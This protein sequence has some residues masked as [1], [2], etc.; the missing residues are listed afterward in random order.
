MYPNQVNPTDQPVNI[1]APQESSNRRGAPNTLLLVIIAL[2]IALLA[3]TVGFVSGTTS[4]KDTY[5][6]KL[7]QAAKDYASLKKELDVQSIGSGSDV[8][9]FSY[10]NIPEW[11]IRMPLN[12]KYTDVVY[13]LK[14]ELGSTYVEITSATL[15]KISTC[16]NYEGQIGTITKAKSGTVPEPARQVT[17]FDEQIYMFKQFD[18]TCT[19]NPQGVEAPYKASILEQFA[20]LEPMPVER[21]TA[22]KKD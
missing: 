7:E 2:V 22:D 9:H 15:A 12:D 11:K 4:Q 8:S 19:S 21:V 13:R 1:Q 14:T 10:L 5:E 18:Q 20:K 17:G 6:Q 3:A 16:V